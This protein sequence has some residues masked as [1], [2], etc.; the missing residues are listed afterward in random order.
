M[1]YPS[2]KIFLSKPIREDDHISLGR[3]HWCGTNKKRWI[4]AADIYGFGEYISPKILF[5]APF[6]LIKS[7]TTCLACGQGTPVLAVEASGYTPTGGEGHDLALNLAFFLDGGVDSLQEWPVYLTNVQEYPPE[8][9]KLIR[10]RSFLFR[11][12]T[13][14]EDNEYY[15]NACTFCKAPIDDFRLFYEQEGPLARCNPSPTRTETVLRYD[16]PIISEAQFA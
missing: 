16:L 3:S 11:K 6:T 12:H 4:Y 7:E 14:G 5:K 2:T 13:F 15:A 8:L 1:K 10:M 9:L